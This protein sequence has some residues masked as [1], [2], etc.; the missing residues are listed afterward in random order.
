VRRRMEYATDA[1]ALTFG[2]RP[3]ALVTGLARLNRLSQVPVRWSPALEW[4]LTHP[5][6]ERRAQR[7]AGQAKLDPAT[8]LPLVDAPPPVAAR[9]AIPSEVTGERLFNSTFR[10]RVSKRLVW[11]LLATTAVVPAL[12]AAALGPWGPV[13]RLA[14]IAL[15][16]LAAFA[17]WQGL[18][19]IGAA[20]PLASLRVAIARRLNRD[21][22][23]CEE[24]IGLSPGG[25]PRLYEGFS[26]WDA[27]FVE[28]THDGLAYVGEEAR[29]ALRRDEVVDVRLEQGFPAWIPV[30]VVRVHW[31]RGDGTSGVFGLQP[32]GLGSVFGSRAAAAGL[33]ARLRA[34]HEG[35]EP[36]AAATPQRLSGGPSPWRADG[37]SPPSPDGI[38]SMSPRDAVKPAQ[39]V[40]TMILL[41]LMSLAVT[42]LLGLP[43]SPFVRGGL[44]AAV[45]SLVAYA[46]AIVPLARWREGKP[47]AAPDTGARKAA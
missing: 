34:W 32:I 7:V 47:Q 45:G 25:T 28:T 41:W 14:G 36:A 40:A 2:V 38:T 37:A 27:G 24:F 10:Q 11:T 5:S 6:T 13:P 46:I 33:H 22:G 18:W 3:E 39:I 29:F 15:G 1:R 8:L 26:M 9:Y 16:A 43:L 4:F 12:T 19:A 42:L 20:R 23:G 30:R 17:T 44:D 35:R 21:D 31:R